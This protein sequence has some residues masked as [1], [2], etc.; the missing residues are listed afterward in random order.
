E[1]FLNR[2]PRGR[3]VTQAAYKHMNI[4]PN[5]TQFSLF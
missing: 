2:T 1:G 5:E 4:S 3:E